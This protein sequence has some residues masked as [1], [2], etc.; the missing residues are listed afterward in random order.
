MLQSRWMQL[1]RSFRYFRLEFWFS[2]PLLGLA[3][4]LFCGWMTQELLIKFSNENIKPEISVKP[5]DL[6]K[7]Q[8][9][10]SIV[11][12]VNS[13]EGFSMVTAIKEIRGKRTRGLKTLE[14]KLFTTDLQKIET[15]IAKQLELPP[16]QVRKLLGID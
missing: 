5:I 11:L 3:F 8:E 6:S 7:Y 12:R 4:W 15:E 10:S 14:F 1:I 9:Y 2:L 13:Q 16:K